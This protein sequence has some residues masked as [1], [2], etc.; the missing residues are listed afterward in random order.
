MG[1]G[2]GAG[3]EAEVG[4]GV[5]AVAEVGEGANKLE[6]CLK[7]RE[8]VYGGGRAFGG[9]S[10]SGVATGCETVE[11]FLEN[12]IRPSCLSCNMERKILGPRSAGVPSSLISTSH[13][14][15]LYLSAMTSFAW[16]YRRF[17]FPRAEGGLLRST[18]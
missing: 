10:T 9:E 2:A 8:G 17:G 15:A 5:K 3:V 4:V 14:E 11:R 7:F 16:W 12:K 13:M 18:Y 6:S 1:A